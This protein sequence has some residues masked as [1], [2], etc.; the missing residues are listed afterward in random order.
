[1]S[2][3]WKKKIYLIL[4]IVPAILLF[5]G[6]GGLTNAD[7]NA[8]SN[9][10]EL[11]L[12]REIQAELAELRVENNDLRESND[13]LLEN[14]EELARQDDGDSGAYANVV[15][16]NNEGTV[17]ANAAQN[18]TQNTAPANEPIVVEIHVTAPPEPTPTP[19]PTPEPVSLFGRW[20]TVSATRDGETIHVPAEEW[21]DISILTGGTGALRIEGETRMFNWTGGDTGASGRINLTFTGFFGD[22]QREAMTYQISDSRLY[23]THSMF[24]ELTTTILEK[25]E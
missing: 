10:D 7:S 16:A 21:L 13:R 17:P 14:I 5:A 3:L 2:H 1:M 19:T 25:P 4:L 18:T 23:L 22:I 24:D 20:V 11:A 9:A 8:N 12:L 15:D 6:C